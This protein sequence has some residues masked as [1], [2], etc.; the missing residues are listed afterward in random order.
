MLE[1]ALSFAITW[2]VILAPPVFLRWWQQEPLS[3]VAALLTV[4]GLH[5]LNHVI[6]AVATGTSGARPILT[7][8]AIVTWFVLRWQ[9]KSSAR[10]A[11]ARERQSLG[12][13][14]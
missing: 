2:L 5:V 14:E 10:A 13:P 6:F 4:I 7:I 9:T 12:Y 8:G 3:K 11:A 1:L